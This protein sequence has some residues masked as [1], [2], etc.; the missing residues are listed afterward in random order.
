MDAVLRYHVLSGRV[1]MAHLVKVESASTMHGV[2]LRITVEEGHMSING[3]KVI[4]SDIA[5]SNGVIHII[6]EVLLPKQ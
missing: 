6:D 2:P 1:M 4:G 3:S 5:V